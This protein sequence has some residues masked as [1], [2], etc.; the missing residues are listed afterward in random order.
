MLLAAFVEGPLLLLADRWRRH[1]LVAIGVAL[2]GVALLVAA[3]AGSAWVFGVALGVWGSA[4]GLACALAQGQLMDTHPEARER[5]MARWTL[6]GSLGDAAAPL[7]L[8]AAAALGADW[9][10]ALALVGAVHLLHAAVLSRTRIGEGGRAGEA[11]LTDP[12]AALDAPGDEADHGDLPPCNRAGDTEPAD[13]PATPQTP[14]GGADHGDL[15]PRERTSERPT[16]TALAPGEEADDGETAPHSHGSEDQV[17]GD[18]LW[19]RLRAGLRDRELLTWL[20]AC[21]LCCLLDEILVV[22]GALHLRDSFGAGPV[23]Q[24]V[25]FAVTAAGEAV[26]LLISERL[27][28]RVDPMRLLTA[29]ALACAL[30]YAAWLA[31]PTLAAS[32]VLLA[33]LGLVAAPLYPICA[34][35]A[36]ATRPGQSGLVAAVDQLFT[37]VPIVAPLALG[38]LADR[39][40]LL[41]ALT[42]LMLQPLGLALLAVTRRHATTTTTT[43]TAT[44]AANAA[45][46]STHP[47]ASGPLD[48]MDASAP[49]CETRPMP[50]TILPEGWKRPRGYANGMVARG[51]LLTVAGQI[52]WNAAEQ[53]E[54]EDFAGQFRQALANVI[55]VVEAAGGRAE[56]LVS[57]T[58]YV[59]DTREYVAAL[60]EVGAAYRELMGK[61]YPTMAL[62]G[63]HQLLEPRAKVEIQALAVLPD[64]ASQA[65][66]A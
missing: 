12:P 55:A 47:P 8:L 11:E 28:A 51:E 32:V 24:G 64:P 63:I 4:G 50:R 59:T 53:F 46:A 56:H 35:R 66:P 40:G 34:A 25:A 44:E 17:E 3:A 58:I 7:A 15:P 60:A 10:A 23:M 57:L 38:W 61:H 37:P 9:R 31:A 43:T 14:G 41:V 20:G 27:L 52:G 22:F 18:S 13:P 42:M 6:M 19:Q 1:R 48:P 30:C 36:Y 39:S 54:A 45:K 33:L 5:W 49:P 26:G 65:S 2:M 29:A 16:E 62:I 21:A